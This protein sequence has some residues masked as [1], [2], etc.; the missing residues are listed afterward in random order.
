MELPIAAVAL[1]KNESNNQLFYVLLP[2][3][4]MIVV[5]GKREKFVTEVTITTSWANDFEICIR[6]LRGGVRM[7]VWEQGNKEQVGK[8]S[9]SLTQGS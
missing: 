8:S 5:V 6:H 4:M 7:R 3:T 1:I 2:M 9:S